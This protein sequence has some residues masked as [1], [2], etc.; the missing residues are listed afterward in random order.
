MALWTSNESWTKAFG[1]LLGVLKVKQAIEPKRNVCRPSIVVKYSLHY[2][3]QGVFR[4]LFEGPPLNLSSYLRHIVFK[5]SIDRARFDH[6]A[7][8]PV[9]PKLTREI[10]V[11]NR[12]FALQ[13]IAKVLQPL[14]V[15][16]PCA[17]YSG[18]R[19]VLANRC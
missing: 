2:C 15:P 18:T 8:Y 10:V 7:E 17:Y 11:V 12:V 4:E 14:V 6:C 3:A 9:V 19:V 16:P 1:H 5:K 13:L